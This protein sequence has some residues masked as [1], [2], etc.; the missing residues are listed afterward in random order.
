MSIIA[1]TN[2][3]NIDMKKIFKA[4]TALLIWA[5]GIPATAGYAITLLW[6]NILPTVCAVENISVLQG[7]GIF[8]LGQLAS[9]GFIVGILILGALT[10]TLGIH[11][12]KHYGHW[13]EM[14]DEQR[15]E[16]IN[17]RRQWNEMIHNRRSNPTDET[18]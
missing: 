13:H 11:H 5:I 10:H 14:T 3:K 8:F 16:F 7:V 4:I 6:N 9:A 12:H 17:H 1:E 15:R 18:E 2:Q